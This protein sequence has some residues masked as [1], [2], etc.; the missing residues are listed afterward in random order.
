MQKPDCSWSCDFPQSTVV[1]VLG[2]QLTVKNYICARDGGPYR[3]KPSPSRLQLT[4]LPTGYCDAKC[5]FCIA[6]PT[7]DRRRLD[8]EKLHRTLLRLKQDDAVRG[9]SISGGEPTQDIGFLNEITGIIFD[10]FG[11]IMEVTLD[12]NG[13]AL[14]RL[15]DLHDLYRFDAVHISRHHWDDRVNEGI[16]GRTMPTGAA[17]KRELA[18]IGC[19]DLFVFNCLMMK[20]VVDDPEDAHTY[21]DFA[22]D[23]GACKVA[24]ITASAVNPWIRDRLVD[25]DDVLR[26]G[27]ERLLFTRSYR[28]HDL[29][30]CRD[31]V[32]V[33]KD[34]RLIEFYGRDTAAQRCAYCRSL[35][36]C[37]DDRLL[38]GFGGEEIQG[39]A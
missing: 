17:L 23:A 34:G 3:Q 39:D 8:P 2:K 12:T 11:P 5:P 10:V 37:P 13:T 24:F 33:S 32:Y 16:F 25:F 35:V 20:G 19:P 6:A 29:C 30:R 28:D 27:D 21:L 38:A 36:Y 22:I 7:T 14:H 26:D 1:S 4:I 31:G 18:L 15:R 9:I